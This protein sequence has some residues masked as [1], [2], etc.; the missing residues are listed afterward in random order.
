MTTLLMSSRNTDDNQ[1]LWRAAVA[2]DWTFVRA[3]G[4]RI[5]EIDDEEVVIYVESLFAPTI[6]RSLGKQLLQLPED[7]LVRLPHEFK[8]REVALA[9]L[10][11]ARSLTEPAFIKPP[12]D[13][14]FA[15]KVYATG[16]SLPGEYDNDMLVLIA[17]PV[18]WEAEFRCFCLDGEVKTLSPY[19]RSGEYAKQTNYTLTEKKRNEATAFTQSVLAATSSMTPRSVVVDVGQI[20]GRGWAVVDANATWGSGI[21]GC[22]PDVVLDV[23]R[24]ATVQLGK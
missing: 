15:A 23:L 20:K 9:T 1:A 5:P 24:Q 13:K 3:Q 18:P 22:D 2:R 7:W 21:Y 8:Q 16:K 11:K 17:A 4:V 19:L 10:E 6:A 14:S 12:N